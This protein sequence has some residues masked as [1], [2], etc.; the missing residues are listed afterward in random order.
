MLFPFAAGKESNSIVATL[1][2]YL[3]DFSDEAFRLEKTCLLSELNEEKS[4]CIMA[5]GLTGH[6]KSTLLNGVIGRKMFKPGHSTTP[7][8]HQVMEFTEQCENSFITVLDTPG[9]NDLE[10]E[11]QEIQEKCERVDTLLYCISIAEC[12]IT[13]ATRNQI[14]TTVRRLK[15]V[16]NKKETIWKSCVVALTFANQAISRFEDDSEIEDVT[17]QFNFIVEDW[18]KEIQRILSKECI[19]NYNEIPIVATGVAKKP[20][21]LRND[22][23]AWLSTLW[24]TIYEESPDNGKA[25]LIHFNAFRLSVSHGDYSPNEP[26]EC[27]KPLHMQGIEIKEPLK[28]KLMKTLERKFPTIAA[29]VGVGGTTGAAG[30]AIGATVGALAI[31]V[32]SFGVFAAVGL[33]LGGLIGGGVGTGVGV[34]TGAAIE[35]AIK[36]KERSETER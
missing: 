29:A 12:R 32:P 23:T 27:L 13:D 31:G 17:S 4:F 6:G 11:D 18:K 2:E 3:D 35:H 7:E 36:K 1:K 5:C 19:D 34:A 26:Q 14:S 25:V 10:N 8:T 30:A 28:K 20:K 24:N 33:V 16:F 22:E 21:L 9:F 15:Q